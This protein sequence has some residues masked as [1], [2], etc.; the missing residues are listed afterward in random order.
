LNLKTFLTSTKAYGIGVFSAGKGKG[1]P[2]QS[3]EQV[4]KSGFNQITGVVVDN[5][6]VKNV[7]I[8]FSNGCVTY[9]PVV[10][11]HFWFVGKVGT[12]EANAYSKH[13]IGISNRGD[14]IS[15]QA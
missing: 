11:G 8:T 3:T 9:V 10:D 2:L 7:V 6:N 1:M 13:I 4:L 15:N 14:I 12:S 5:P